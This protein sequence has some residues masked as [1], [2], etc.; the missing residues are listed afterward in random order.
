MKKILLLSDTH[1][2]IDEQILKFV[3]QADE[4][5]HA[6]DIGNISVT[7]EIQKIKPLRAVYGNIDDKTIRSEFPLHQKFTIENVPVWITHIGGYPNRYD[8]SIRNE[9]NQ[10]PPKLFISGHS[11]ILKVM[12]DK[13]LN[14]LHI[15]PG[16]AGK[17]GFHKVRT[18][19]RFEINNDKIEN[20]E[21]IELQKR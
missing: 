7:D 4:V 6:G 9:I 15:N 20:L 12:F 21:V 5:W 17:H 10:N 8:M 3:K 18:M 16:A 2:Y 11:H 1:N 14:L 13:K 19:T